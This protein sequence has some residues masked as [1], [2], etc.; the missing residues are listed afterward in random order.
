[1]ASIHL[2]PMQHTTG[3]QSFMNVTL[4]S[5]WMDMD[6]DFALKMV[7]GHLKLPNARV[8]PRHNH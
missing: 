2:H 6:E 3:Q 8:S 4:I 1:M 7:P 5:N